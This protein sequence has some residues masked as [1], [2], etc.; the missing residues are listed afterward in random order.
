MPI[1][2]NSQEFQLLLRQFEKGNVVLF[3]GAG[4]SLGAANRSGDDPPTGKDLAKLLAER[5]G[6]TYRD[7]ELP[8]VYAQARTHLGSETLWGFLDELYKDCTPSAWQ[9]AV[10]ELLWYRIFT[11]NID[12]VI[13][14]SY[15]K[16]GAQ[17]LDLITCP[18]PFQE[19]DQFYERV[20]CVHLHGCVLDRSKLLTFTLEELADQTAKPS[21]WYQTMIANMLGKSF[22]FVGTRLSEPPFNHYLRLR[23]ERERG[24]PE[25]RAKAFLISPG[26][27]SIYRRQFEDQNFV[28]IDANA[29]NFFN[30]LVPAVAARVATR[31]DLLKNRYPHQIAA[32]N[33]GAFD[34]QSVVLRQFELVAGE[35]QA[36]DPRTHSYFYD[37]AE[38]SWNDIRTG[39]DAEREVTNE[40]LQEL[41]NDVE[42]V[43]VFAIVGQ[44]G[45][46]KSTTSKRVGFELFRDGRA[47]YFATTRQKLEVPPILDLI[48]SLGSRHVFLFFDDARSHVTSV[49]R[50]VKALPGAANVTFVLTDRTHILLPKLQRARL[51][52][53]TLEMPPLV[54]PDCERIISKL[55]QFGL[56]GALQGLTRQERLREFLGRSRKQLLVAMKEA[57]SGRGFNVIIEDEYRTLASD[58][59]RLAYAITCLAYVHFAPVRRRHLIACLDGNDIEKANTLESDLNGVVISW[60]SSDHLLSPRHRVIADHVI[61]GPVTVAVR[62]EAV[63]RYLAQIS[64]DINPTTVRLRTAEFIAYR[65]IINFDSMQDLFGSDY[66]VIDGI[67]NELKNYYGEDYLFWL[68]Y[69]RAQV[70]FDNFSVAENYLNQSL[71]IRQNF[72]AEHYMGV[73]FLKRALYR[74][75]PSEAA[76]DAKKGEEILREQI[77]DRGDSDPYP[78]SALVTHKFRYLRKYGTTKL[79]EEMEELK[80]LAESGVRNHP[81]HAPLKD[82]YK[83]VLRA[84]LSLAV[85]D[86]A[87]PA[88]E[89]EEEDSAA[90][91]ALD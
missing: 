70:Y 89:L 56:L 1:D 26:L 51:R 27:T 61:T 69:G 41:T 25:H 38:P 30:V 52:T 59:A 32:I 73:L 46:G 35:A 60:G 33:E 86:G 22:V 78:D 58:N 17:R 8:I 80:Q 9:H 66:D 82:A 50:I 44:A 63:K 71:G 53:V 83:E 34:A 18:A 11:T 74:D 57:T 12:D 75:H 42:G 29:E 31:L 36:T 45:S 72:Q 7:E 47:V 6:W 90:D 16:G 5:C 14:N 21:P 84:Y 48:N 23:S 77:R 19:Q 4:F 76:A 39:I 40:F 88:S 54:R 2:T 62:E 87:Q 65:G 43:K 91:A 13:E 55:E 81:L 64:S 79:Q 49:A 85:S 37:G 10:T 24:V 20:Q 67:Y 3:A 68:Q 15:M 28:V